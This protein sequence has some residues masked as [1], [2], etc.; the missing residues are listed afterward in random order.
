MANDK[1][2][3]PQKIRDNAYPLDHVYISANADAYMD[4]LE[5]GWWKLSS[6]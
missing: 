3:L 1:V 5:T 6:V 2:Q 4:Q